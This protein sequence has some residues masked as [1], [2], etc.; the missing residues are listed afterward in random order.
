MKLRI[1]CECGNCMEVT[2]VTIGQIAYFG[3][4]AREHDFDIQGE[5]F[6]V[7]LME[8]AV[9]DPN[10]VEVKIKELRIDCRKCGSYMILNC[11]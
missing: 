7:D 5:A 4:I 8:E 10:D 2:P 9:S 3:Q 6:D 1:E 11:E